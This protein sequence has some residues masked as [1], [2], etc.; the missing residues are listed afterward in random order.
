[1]NFANWIAR[2]YECVWCGFK[3]NAVPLLRISRALRQISVAHYARAMGYRASVN[4]LWS[5]RSG[6]SAMKQEPTEGIVMRKRIEPVGTP[7]SKPFL[8]PF[9]R[10]W[11]LPCLRKN[12]LYSRPGRQFRPSSVSPANVNVNSRKHIPYR[13]FAQMFGLE[14]RGLFRYTPGCCRFAEHSY[15]STRPPRY[16]DLKI[17]LC[18]RSIEAWKPGETNL[19]EFAAGE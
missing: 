4:S 11:L 12:P 13:L 2:C 17:V 16:S 1:M 3:A 19:R 18:A 7:D 15:K 9:G 6:D 14:K 5:G 8:R 10:C